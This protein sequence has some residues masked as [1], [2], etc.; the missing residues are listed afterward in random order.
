M[1]TFCDAEKWFCPESKRCKGR[2]GECLDASGDT[3][4]TRPRGC[5]SPWRPPLDRIVIATL[6][7]LTAR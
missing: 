4:G 3:D 1:R 5:S 2:C 7:C 6:V